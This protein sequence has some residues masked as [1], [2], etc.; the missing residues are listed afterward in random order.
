MNNFNNLL[1][2]VVI[3]LVVLAIGFLLFKEGRESRL[4]KKGDALV[5]SIELFKSKYKRLPN[6]IKELGLNEKDG[7]DEVY[8][9]KRDSV[10]YTV[11]FGTSLGESKF[12]YSDSKQWEDFYRRMKNER[13]P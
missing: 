2:V 3:F 11:S 1:K 7:I 5:N 13:I 9:T 12:Y 4:M 8:Y 10:N 6:N